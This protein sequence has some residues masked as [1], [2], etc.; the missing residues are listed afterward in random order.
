MADDKLN[1]SDQRLT[2]SD[3]RLTESEQRLTSANEDRAY[4]GQLNDI[5]AKQGKTWEDLSVTEALN[6]KTNPG[7]FIAELQGLNWQPDYAKDKLRAEAESLRSTHASLEKTKTALEMVARGALVVGAGNAGRSILSGASV[8]AK[9]LLGKTGEVIASNVPRSISKG[10]IGKTV[11]KLSSIVEGGVTPTAGYT[12]ELVGSILGDVSGNVLSKTAGGEPLDDNMAT[13][14]AIDAGAMLGLSAGG[15]L[16]GGVG[17][18]LGLSKSEAPIKIAQ[19]FDGLV[20][21]TNPDKLLANATSLSVKDY[22]TKTSRKSYEEAVSALSDPIFMRSLKTGKH[23]LFKHIEHRI[24]TTKKVFNINMDKLLQETAEQAV[25]EGKQSGVLLRDLFQ[26]IEN[27][28]NT[29]TT[30]AETKALN[31]VYNEERKS[32]MSQLLPENVGRQYEQAVKV[33]NRLKNKKALLEVVGENS[34][35]ANGANQYL[36]EV[37]KL[38]NE[39]RQLRIAENFIK[40]VDTKFLGTNIPIQRALEFKRQYANN[41]TFNVDL[42]QDAAKRNK[43][44]A[45]GD[46]ERSMRK[47]LEKSIAE[48]S[49]DKLEIYQKLNHTYSNLKSIEPNIQL[50]SA[51]EQS[52]L[53]PSLFQRVKAVLSLNEEGISARGFLSSEMSKL[54]ALNK[55][56]QIYRAADLYKHPAVV[57]RLIGE[58]GSGVFF[59]YANSNFS[60]YTPATYETVKTMVDT[61][62]NSTELQLPNTVIEP[63]IKVRD[64]LEAGLAPDSTEESKTQMLLSLKLDPETSDL[65]ETPPEKINNKYLEGVNTII[66]GK[67]ADPTGREQEAVRMKIIKDD[68]LDPTTKYLM[69]NPLN[70][71]GS[72]EGFRTLATP[73]PTTDPQSTKKKSNADISNNVKNALSKKDKFKAT[74]RSRELE[75]I[76]EHTRQ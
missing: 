56:A 41:A 51:A 60:F 30:G 10:V 6:Y 76:V 14:A 25:K 45:Y 7:K 3:Q 13:Q 37:N 43:A 15:R 62:L 26:P 73:Q 72:L 29:L 28:I 50:L 39:A 20:D 5:L 35:S 46:L 74:M 27:K 64:T 2:E 61:A 32:L 12:G 55:A 57:K 70:K 52:H 40:E 68:S 58:A 63:L 1:E 75:S 21:N 47:N 36:K 18:I 24:A 71:A 23:K 69:L 49:P 11:G 53:S 66:D 8:A 17:G 67:I 44:L 9:P 16:L 22:F 4:F 42:L 31:S 59:K 33:S 34:I 48:I 65:F 38:Y 54:S 19:Y